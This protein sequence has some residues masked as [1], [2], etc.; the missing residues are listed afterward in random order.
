[1]DFRRIDV[2][3]DGVRIEL[4]CFTPFK[5]NQPNIDL[6]IQ[7]DNIHQIISILK[8]IYDVSTKN[9]LINTLNI[10]LKNNYCKAHLTIN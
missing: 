6:Q 1:M 3:I 8:T 5:N 2:L 7:K 4:A 10:L 9:Y